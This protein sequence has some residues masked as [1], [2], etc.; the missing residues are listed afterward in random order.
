MSNYLPCYEDSNAQIQKAVEA[1]FNMLNLD[2][3]FFVAYR[4]NLTHVI[5]KSIAGFASDMNDNVLESL[6]G[7]SEK[8]AW[9]AKREEALQLIAY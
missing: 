8:R 1:A 6:R 4:D 2:H 5:H 7:S 3:D 9:E